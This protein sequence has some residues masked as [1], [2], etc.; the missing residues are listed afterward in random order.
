MI[1]PQQRFK[2]VIVFNSNRTQAQIT[3]FLNN[4]VK[5]PF[6]AK[7]NQVLTAN[8]ISY[9]LGFKYKINKQ[10]NYYEVYPKIIISGETNLTES[11][12]ITGISN[13]LSDLKTIL[14]TN[15]ETQPVTNIRFHIQYPDFRAKV[16]D[17]F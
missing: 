10:G 6:E 12:L 7:I 16:S 1:L 4:T 9:N 14:K 17:E 5:A 13:L 15:F 3:N 8:F 11:Q 2:I